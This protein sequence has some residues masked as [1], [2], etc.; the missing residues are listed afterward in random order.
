MEQAL[1]YH[2]WF[3]VLQDGCEPGVRCSGLWLPLFLRFAVVEIAFF[4]FPYF[5]HLPLHFWSSPYA[6]CLLQHLLL[7]LSGIWSSSSASL[8]SRTHGFIETSQPHV[9][10]T[11]CVSLDRASLGM[12][13]CCLFVLME[14]CISMFCCLLGPF[15]ALCVSTMTVGAVIRLDSSHWMV[16]RLPWQAWLID[17][18][19]SLCSS[20]FC[21]PCG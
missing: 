9:T 10:G 21:L 12:C 19:G 6:L 1:P 16:S 4:A 3:S 7:H 2:R 20:E 15:V 17:V 11:W 8:T 18:V 13:L 5:D 14:P